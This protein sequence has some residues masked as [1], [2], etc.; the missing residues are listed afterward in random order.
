MRD[1]G[2][3]FSTEQ[4]PSHDPSRLEERSRGQGCYLAERMADKP[5]YHDLGREGLAIELFKGFGTGRPAQVL[6]E[7]GTG[8]AAEVPAPL[9]PEQVT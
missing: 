5:E 3:P 4:L 9:A 6:L 7:A 8:A 2:I 1:K